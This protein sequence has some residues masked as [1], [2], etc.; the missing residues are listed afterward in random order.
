[1]ASIKDL[2]TRDASNKVERT[3]IGDQ[4]IDYLGTDSDAFITAKT[5]VQRDVIAHKI[6]QDDVESHLVA[7]LV[8]AWSFDEECTTANKVALFKNSPSFC[9]AI[10]RVAS[11]RANFTKALQ[12]ASSNTAGGNS[13]KVNQSTQK[14]KPN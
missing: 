5:N 7:S 14:Q 4:W 6:K 3:T 10:D 1:M 13:G 2:Y 8:T 11:D 12:S 9:A